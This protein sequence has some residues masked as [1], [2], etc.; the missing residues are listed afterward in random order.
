MGLSYKGN[1]ND[2]SLKDKQLL[3]N[4]V[5]GISFFQYWKIFTWRYIHHS[6]LTPDKMVRMKRNATSLCWRYKSEPN[7]NWSHII[8]DCP[9]V[10]LYWCDIRNFL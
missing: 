1:K 7:A 2:L 6:F 5:S 4:S 10:Q 8:L 9:K 3:L